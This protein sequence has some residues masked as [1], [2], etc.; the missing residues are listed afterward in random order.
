[1]NLILELANRNLKRNRTRSLL[2]TVGVVVGVV[3]ISSLGVYGSS[4]T[5]SI[6]SAFSDLATQ[7]LV[8]PAYENGYSNINERDVQTIE[9][10]KG[11]SQLSRVS[12]ASDQIRAGDATTYIAIYG[13]SM[14]AISSYGIEKGRMIASRNADSCLIGRSLAEKHELKIGQRIELKGRSLKIDGIL[15]KAP[16]GT[17]L[18][19]DDAILLSREKFDSFYKFD[20]MALIIRAG[21]V[22]DV[23]RIKDDIERRVNFREKKV[24]VQVMKEA[25]EMLE[26]SL[27]SVTVFLMA[28]GGVS[29]VVA[30]VG[31]LNVMLISTIE[32]RREIGT[33][34]AI[35][36]KPNKILKMFFYE[37]FIIGIKGC[38][39]GIGVSLGVGFF[40]NYFFIGDITNLFSTQTMFYIGIGAIM[41][42][43]ICVLS[44]LYPAYKAANMEPVEALR[45]E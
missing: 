14:E 37:A 44:A 16:L 1:M 34:L 35:G 20:N 15:E 23:N 4:I 3:C 27:Q 17:V 7:I 22:N 41:G 24:N 42:I 31:I 2:T 12:W 28:I 38:I 19:M 39:I 8:V 11:I 30:G 40:I 36:G 18:S 43:G 26:Q 33:M 45:Y 21:N 5:A 25:L 10:I 32:R 6:S 13:L 9:R 29:L